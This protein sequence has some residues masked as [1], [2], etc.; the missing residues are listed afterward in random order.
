MG[1]RR[2]QVFRGVAAG[3]LALL[4][5][6]GGAVPAVAAVPEGVV[7][8]A[9]APGAVAGS[10]LVVLAPQQGAAVAAV[11]ASLA[12]R[13]GGVLGRSFESALRG[14]SVRLPERQAR[15]LAA[16]PAVAL[17]AQ[18]RRVSVDGSQAGPPSWGLDRVDQ[19]RPPLTDRFDYPAGGGQGVTVY[20]V[21]TGVRISHEDFGGRASY[22]FDAVD[23]DAVADDGNGHGTH[24]AATAVGATYGVAKRASLVAVRVLDDDGSGTIEQVVAGVD[25]V[26][27]H[28]VKPAVVNMSLGGDPDEVLDAAVRNSIASGLTYTVAAGN[29]GV[30][31]SQHSPA[32]VPT[33]ITVGA[34][35]VEDD[36]TWYSNYGP[37]VDLHA[38]GEEI[39]SAGI[40]YDDDYDVMSGTSMASPHVAGAAAL[41]LADHRTATPAQVSTA[42]T[43]ASTTG[44]IGAL[45]PGTADR[46]LYT[47]SIPNRAP[48][49]RFTNDADTP[50]GVAPLVSS[51]TVT[52]VPGSGPAN[53]DVAV[54]IVHDWPYDLV[55]DLVSPAGKVFRLKEENFS[56]PFNDVHKLYG[57]D[58][59]TGAANGVWQLRVTG[60][61]EYFDGYLDRWAL[62]F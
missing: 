11:G 58:A 55:I 29:Q 62:Q 8:G 2:R 14:F 23:G 20:V 60:G 35:D 34:T 21:D 41:Y 31:A 18:N 9:G 4:V 6:A 10:Y 32:R 48:G 53:L 54:D 59:S 12:A 45:E 13:Y 50:I 36:V 43:S 40:A 61:S 15:R 27:A 25:W 19:R 7:R 30:D 5:G 37:L 51:I 38:P 17:V 28:A 39:T 49:R 56:G 46:L 24:V 57:V 33:A 47:G 1:V 26:T 16:D 44:S 3:A 52:G 42:L 22:G